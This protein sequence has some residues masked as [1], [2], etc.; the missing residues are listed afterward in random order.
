MLDSLLFFDI[1]A[2]NRGADVF[3]ELS[4]STNR[5]A[6]VFIEMPCSTKINTFF[7]RMVI[8]DSFYNKSVAQHPNLSM[9]A[10]H[11]VEQGI[12]SEIN[13]PQF[14]EQGASSEINALQ[15]FE[16]QRS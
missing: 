13:A 1:L 6:N 9:L 15:F 5:G 7:L 16:F 11:F 8:Y 12:S 10:P 14:M 3:T 4:C 2:L